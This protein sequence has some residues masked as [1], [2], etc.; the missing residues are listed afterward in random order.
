MSD[1]RLSGGDG[2]VSSTDEDGETATP[3]GG[4]K[5]VVSERSVDDILES[6]SETK[7]TESKPASRTVE[8]STPTLSEVSESAANT[9]VPGNVEDDGDQMSGDSEEGVEDKRDTDREEDTVSAEFSRGT[10][11]ASVD[12]GDLSARVDAGEVTGADVRA[13]EAGEGREPTPEVD[14]I[15][16]TLEDLDGASGV[17]QMT[18][19]SEAEEDDEPAETAQEKRDSGDESGGL[20]ARIRGLFSR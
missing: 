18:A 2:D 19:G 12:S 4:P 7:E 17:E 6:L 20:L 16:L 15:E 8:G 3:S 14:E 10:N 1:D 11:G 5:R 13:A 9:D